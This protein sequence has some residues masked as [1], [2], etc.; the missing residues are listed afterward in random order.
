M[1]WIRRQCS[2]ERFSDLSYDFRVLSCKIGLSLAPRPLF[3]LFA[4]TDIISPR[5]FLI[6]KELTWKKR[7]KIYLKLLK[8]ITYNAYIRGNLIHQ[9]FEDI[10]E[11]GFSCFLFF[12][13]SRIG[14]PTPHT[15]ISHNFQFVTDA[16]A[17]YNKGCITFTKVKCWKLKIRYFHW[18]LRCSWILRWR[19]WK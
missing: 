12:F 19:W 17:G 16:T 1:T 8:F 15:P 4:K 10:G 14:S 7:S 3:F 13:F 5:R 11:D 2:I 9:V 6:W 18:I